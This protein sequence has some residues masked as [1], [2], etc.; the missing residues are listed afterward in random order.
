M[1][2]DSS[3]SC[4]FSNIPLP[5]PP[6]RPVNGSQRADGATFYNNAYHLR[7]PQPAHSNQFSYVQADQQSLRE[8]P[9]PPFHNR[10]HFG[11]S[12]DGGGFY[13]DHDR[14]KLAPNE[15][16]DTWRFSGPSFSAPGSYYRDPA[17][18]PYPPSP[19]TGPPCEPPLPS[20]GWGFPPRAM[21]H[22]ELMPHRS[23]FEGPIPLQA[24]GD[25]DN[26][27]Y[28]AS[29]SGTISFSSPALGVRDCT[30][31]VLSSLLIMR[32]EDDPLEIG[33]L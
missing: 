5:H 31:G 28:G 25:Q 16:R 29:G 26:P 21:N 6:I 17:R 24:F 2:P 13:T 7:P 19:Y 10:D 18:G 1:I 32:L 11:Q 4:S 3:S 9:P 30:Y 8:V 20:R 27:Q 14:M 12:T 15:H 33:E 23:P 22:R